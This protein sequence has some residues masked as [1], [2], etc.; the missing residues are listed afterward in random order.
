MIVLTN[1]SRFRSIFKDDKLEDLYQLYYT[2]DKEV[3][4]SKGRR[5]LLV[6]V[7]FIIVTFAIT[8][9]VMRA[10]DSIN[11]LS[12]VVI[13]VVVGGGAF[14]VN[15]SIFQWL[16]SKNRIDHERRENIKLRIELAQEREE[17]SRR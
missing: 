9:S 5:I 15:F 6:F 3:E 1:E 11:I 14:F 2:V 17:E 12:C 16:I 10:T 7:G 8:L 4:A 13:A